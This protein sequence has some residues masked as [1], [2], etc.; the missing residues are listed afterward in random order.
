MV[1]K[2]SGEMIQAFPVT[3]ATYVGTPTDFGPKGY[4]LVHCNED[5]TLTFR[6][7]GAS[8]V[9]INGVAGQDFAIGDGCVGITATAEVAIS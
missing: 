3:S 5:A 2:K 9:I 8:V 7:S 6:F 4:D 1:K